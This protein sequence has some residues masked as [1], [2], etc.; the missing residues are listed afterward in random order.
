MRIVEN[1]YFPIPYLAN[2]S[3]PV[4]LGMRAERKICSLG[5]K[6]IFIWFWSKKHLFDHR[7]SYTALINLTAD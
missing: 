5:L 4:R 2:Y 1:G 7:A 3:P 6:I